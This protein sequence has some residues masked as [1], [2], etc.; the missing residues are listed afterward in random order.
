MDIRGEKQ[1]GSSGVGRASFDRFRAVARHVMLPFVLR[2]SAFVLAI[3]VSMFATSLAQAVHCKSSPSPGL[4]WSNCNKS[5]LMLGRSN[6]EGATLFNADFTSSDLRGT[7]LNSANLEKATLVRASLAG[8]SA[9]GANFA[10]VEAYRISFVGASA[11]GA[12]FVRAGL[13]RANFSQARLTG[14]NFEK[15]E[16]G[17][18]NF[19][20]AVMTGTKFSQ[21]NLARADLTL[22]IF[23]GPIEFDSAFMYLTRIEGLDLSAASGLRQ[24]QI[25]LAC[26]DAATKLPAGLYAP[27]NWPCA[28]D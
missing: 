8:A 11:E 6:L 19:N 23:E 5:M 2:A 18:A 13:Q 10:S 21:A 3:A 14:A 7:N 9:V 26:G 12:S 1:I 24:T 17:R 16:L 20:G 28:F 15:A 25:G 27:G 22:T 4:D